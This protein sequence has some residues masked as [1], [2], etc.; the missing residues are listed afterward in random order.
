[1]QTP[2]V[3]SRGVDTLVLNIYYKDRNSKPYKQPIPDELKEQLDAW[4]QAAIMAEEPV[5]IPLTFEGAALH[6][7]PNGAGKGQWRW[8][9]CCDSIN[10]LVS[11]GRFNG[12]AQVRLSSE[13]LWSCHNV[14]DAWLRVEM[15]VARFLNSRIYVQVSEAHLCVDIA[16]WDV[17]AINQRRDFVSRSHKRSAY[18]VTDFTVEEFSYGL[19]RSGF[20]FSKGSPISC[21]IYD[22]TREIREESLKWW[23]HD[24]WQ[25]SGWDAEKQPQV[26]RVEFRF[27]REVLHELSVEDEFQGI[28]DA[29]QFSDRLQALWAY[30]CGHVG[31]GADGLPDGW[32]RYVVPGA[33]SNRSRWVTHLVWMEV[34]KAFAVLP[35]EEEDKSEVI[36]KRKRQ[37]SLDRATAATVGYLSSMAAWLGCDGSRGEEADFLYML[38]WLRERTPVYLGARQRQFAKEVAKKRVR[39]ERQR[40]AEQEADGVWGLPHT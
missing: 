14:D 25:A 6:M 37:A 23:F 26:W 27:K 33:D 18:E 28:E 29:F 21:A 4:K 22:K 36:R 24:L 15:F 7:Y 10:L 19:H 13:Y 31:G 1:M 39:F 2:M 5:P 38:H 32:L 30:A 35:D 34:Q 8:L 40:Q 12:I 11:M 9:M 20:H 17:E 3:V 16:G